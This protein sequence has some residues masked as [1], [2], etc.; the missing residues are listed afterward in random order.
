MNDQATGYQNYNQMVTEI[1]N[2]LQKIHDVCVSLNMQETVKALEHS[3]EKMKGHKFAVGILGEFKRGKSTVINA[4]MGREIM[5]SD[6]LPTS[7]TM[8]R[9]TYGLNPGAQVHMRNG[10][11]EAIAVDKL[12]D[13]VTKLDKE[14]EAM[15]ELVEE[16]IVFYPCKFCKDGVDIVDTPGLNDSGRMDKIVEE[17]IP[18]LDAVVMVITYDSPISMSESAFIRSKLMTSDIGRLIFLVN[19]MDCVR[20]RDRQ[21]VLDNI[22]VRIEES[23]LGKMKEIHGEDSDIYKDV[24]NKLADIR[25]FPISARDALEGREEND[26]A[27]L[28]DSG[29]LEF[30]AALEKMLTEERSALELGMP[31]AQ[32]YRSCAQA[33][34][35]IETCKQALNIS[36]E[37]FQQTQR[38]TLAKCQEL[39]EDQKKKQKNLEDKAK[40]VKAQMYG[41]ARE[42]YD[43]IEKK[44]GDL[45]N[46][47]TLDNPNKNLNDKD[48]QEIIERVAKQIDELTRQEMA[49]FSERT[50]CQLSEIVGKESLGISAMVSKHELRIADASKPTANLKA[51]LGSIAVDTMATYLTADL[52]PGIGGVIMGYR[53]A[54]VK[55]ALLGGG[56]AFASFLVLGSLLVPLGVVGL[57][58]AAITCASG[59]FVGKAVT[60][61]VFA[62]S[63]NEKALMQLKNQIRNAFNNSSIQM[64]NDREIEKW[65]DETVDGQFAHLIDSMN[66]ECTRIRNQ[67]N[68]TINN[69]RVELARNAADK[70]QRMNNYDALQATIIGIQTYMEPY[71]NMIA[72]NIPFDWES[73][74]KTVDVHIDEQAKQ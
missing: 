46:N 65:I 69:I 37:E 51:T 6:I 66:D 36:Q 15:A 27:L 39:S 26:D 1:S 35:M 24:R 9:V 58:L 49:V 64:R 74:K 12:I 13:Y 20:K 28:I 21:R 73:Y 33:L 16:A 70:Q 44:A 41:E 63:R 56:T 2:N 7:A 11:V 55:G 50:I 42:C 18:K 57:P 23:I 32:I 52:L 40:D 4:L 3:D 43:C 45:I 68:E 17:V 71:R 72:N 38:E 34:E 5:P 30:E 67:A 61:A 10:E 47:I 8:N 54:G 31:I 62:K 14:K 19:K 48:K 29:I 60:D 53:S 59:T 22:R 25:I